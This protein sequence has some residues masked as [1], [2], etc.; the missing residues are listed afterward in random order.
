MSTRTRFEVTAIWDEENA[1]WVSES[2]IRGL[3]VEA[4]TLE[5]FEDLAREF[6]TEL[7][8]QNHYKDANISL[9]NL[10]DWLPSIHFRSVP[11][12]RNA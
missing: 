7:I 9:K 1:I 6:A 2:D 10:K 4:E 12:P 8:V 3:H 5:G 11:G